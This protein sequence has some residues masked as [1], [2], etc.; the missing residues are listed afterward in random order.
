MGGSK[1]KEP[2]VN[3]LPQFRGAG[4]AI[5]STV[6]S[7]VRN[8]RLT[9]Y[10]GDW[11]ADMT[12]QQRSILDQVTQR[13]LGGSP[14]LT[15]A[16]QLAQDTMSGKYLDQGNPYLS[17]AMDA[18][19]QQ[20]NRQLAAQFGGSGMTGSPAHLQFAS[21][22]Y[23]NA[24]APLYMQNYQQER[25]L[26]SAAAQLAPQLANQDFMQLGQA[27]GA[28]EALQ[29][30]SQREIDAQREF[31]DLQ[32][33][34][35]F[36]RAQMGAGAINMNPAGA[37]GGSAGSGGPAAGAAGGAVPGAMMGAASGNPWLALGGSVLGGVGGGLANK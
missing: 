34:E 12:P 32:R 8:Q 2:K 18:G 22:A 29:G 19:M 37:Y 13:G 5:G 20:V 1:A 31:Y 9:P 26:Q 17:G 28:Q 36:R 33:S 15:S 14:L 25:G 16:N 6:E 24:A 4:K 35:P 30:Q 23:S 11:V 10:G 27:L 21:E 3:M 7:A